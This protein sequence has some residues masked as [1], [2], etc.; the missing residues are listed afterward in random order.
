MVKTVTLPLRIEP[1]LGQ[2][3]QEQIY[4]CIRR[5]I[6]EGLLPTDSRL[7]STRTLAVDLGVSR[8]TVLLAFEQLKAEGY[9]VPRPGS[10]IYVAKEL[11]DRRPALRRPARPE[12]HL[13]RQPRRRRAHL[14]GGGPQEGHDGARLQRAAHRHARRRP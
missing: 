11:P 12:D 9:L 4:F 10:G 2:T 14:Q 3:L 6:V 7:P 8:T 1:S 5:S 13:H